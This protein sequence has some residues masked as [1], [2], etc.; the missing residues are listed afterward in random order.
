MIPE[1]TVA[2]IR[3][4]TDIVA[5]VGEYV[6][7]KR[8]GVSF[9]GLCPF[10]NE[11]SPSFYVHPKR[12]F[13]KC[14][15]CG[16][17]GDVFSF[18]MGL[19]GQSFPDTARAL[20][21]RAGIEVAVADP[22][23]EAAHRRVKQ[24]DERL[25]AIMDAATG[26]YIRMLATHPLGSMARDV[27]VQ[28]GVHD[29]TTKTF[30]L[31]YAPH[32]WDGLASFLREQGFSPA[33]AEAVGLLV[34]RRGGSGH[35]D[36]FRHRLMFPVS[37]IHG[38]VVAFSGRA[39]D[40][41]PEEPEREPGA[42]YINSPESPLYTKGQVLFGLHEARVAVRRTGVAVLC[43]GNFDLLAL[44]QAG[45]ENTVAPLG[46]AFTEDHAKL[47]K[48]YAE[49]VVTLFDGDAAGRRAVAAAYPLF[50]RAG[51]GAKVAS[52][53]PGEDP[54]SLLRAQGPEGLQERVEGA[55]P[56]VDH[57]IDAGAHEAAGD[58]RAKAD[59]IM[60]LGPVLAALDNPV[61]AR[62][63]VEKVAQKFGVRD[64][65]AVRE[66]LRRGVRASRGGKRPVGDRDAPRPRHRSPAE[67]EEA[68]RKEA[69]L[70]PLEVKLLGAI[71]DNP[72][73]LRTESA[74]NLEEL[75]TSPDL[76]A[77][78]QATSRMVE[79]RGVVDA[80]ALLSE[81][82]GSPAASWLE[83]RLAVHDHDVR[84]A[85]RILEDGIPRLAR[86]NIERELPRISARILEAIRNG[87]GDL[88][89]ELTERKTALA[90]SAHRLT[91]GTKR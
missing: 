22:A 77:I 86:R 59:A 48:R 72:E 20:A 50:Q 8:S 89:R 53:P 43:E 87:D 67:A 76:R 66:Q 78:F 68:A 5:L 12:G 58:P 62:L 83:Q 36:R 21:E 3:Q 42:K 82:G 28:R 25:A 17:A 65:D 52:L 47:L 41:P 14:F 9:K 1:D 73:L 90:R 57:L 64:L 69:K 40:P 56:I 10:H 55:A 91:Q 71:L 19:E 70:P 84:G 45:F 39:L 85:E 7:L 6:T 16:A 34:P 61:E 79:T 37:D 13:Y 81:L 2:E 51:L 4:R 60:S 27:L 32:G 30:R 33:D 88:A 15:G 23:E 31:G 75:L 26:F 35:Y 18:L 49:R 74:K 46:T 11:K 80:P 38:R 29:E 44:H 63:Y 24:R 54:D